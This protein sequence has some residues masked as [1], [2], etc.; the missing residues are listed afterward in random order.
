MADM[1]N[2]GMTEEERKVMCQAYEQ[3]KVHPN[4]EATPGEDNLIPGWGNASRTFDKKG[5]INRS[6]IS[7]SA[8]GKLSFS[9]RGMKAAKIICGYVEGYTEKRLNVGNPDEGY[10]DVILT[11]K[12]LAE[13]PDATN[14]GNDVERHKDYALDDTEE[15]LWIHETEYLVS[16]R[17][18]IDAGEEYPVMQ[19]DT[20]RRLMR[21][22]EAWASDS[23]VKQEILDYFA[24]YIE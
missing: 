1:T 5:Y 16:G 19:P 7:F 17:S 14:E 22:D 9:N 8:S 23:G 6:Y 3:A 20:Q 11:G 4:N 18:P 2:I 24:M 21:V 10:V 15:G 12:V 13:Y